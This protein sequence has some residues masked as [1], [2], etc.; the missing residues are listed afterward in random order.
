VA[1][2]LSLPPMNSFN[3]TEAAVFTMLP[4]DLPFS[5]I[6]QEANADERVDRDRE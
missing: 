1:W 3:K 2:H 5:Q 6:Y 4:Q